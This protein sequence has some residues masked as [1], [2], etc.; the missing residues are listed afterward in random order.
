ML[1]AAD[2]VVILLYFALTAGIGVGIGF[3]V[4]DINDFFAGGGV[5]PWKLSAI[6]NYMTMMSAFI[7]VAHASIA[8]DHGIVAIVILWSAVPAAIFGA[9]FLAGRWKRAGLV[10]PVEYL[11]L[12]YGSSVRQVTSWIGVFFRVLDNMV[13][14]YAIGVFVS[15]CTP[16]SLE[17]A[18]V[19]CGGVVVLYTMIGGLWA[20]VVTDAVQCAVLV[21]IAIVM[22]PLSITAAGGWQG[23]SDTI[24]THF[25]LQG[26]KSAWS[27]LAAYYLMVSIKFNGNW[28]FIQ[29]FYATESE[30]SARKMGFFSALL[31]LVFPVLFLMPAIAAAAILPGVANSEHAYVAVCQHLLPAG[32]MGLMIAAMFA[33]TMSTLSSEYNVTAAVLTKD[34]YLR[35]LRPQA[36]VREVMVV[37][38]VMTLALG[39]L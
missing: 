5:I 12:R 39:R 13:R 1:Q 37:A 27:Y 2:I 30:S 17:T 19:V 11:E 9:V 24:P 7:F 10:T 3:F 15:A 35:L 31:F 18:V 4:K 6:S 8:Y 25:T 33:A 38:R 32:A 23:L 29:R 28:A 20:V 22:F 36:G 16:M 34:M 14:L 26:P 21:M